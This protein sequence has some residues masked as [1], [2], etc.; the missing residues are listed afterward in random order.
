MTIRTRRIPMAALAV[1]GLFAVPAHAGT[2]VVGSKHDLRATGGVGSTPIGTNL[3]QVCVTCH[4]PHQAAGVGGAG[5]QD[6]LWNHTV[7]SQGL[8]GVYASTTAQAV[9]TDFGGGG[10]PGALNTSQLCMSC[11]DGTVGVLSMY[12]QPNQGGTPTVA[13][14]L[15]YTA[16]GL[17][18]AS[19]PGNV[20]T[21]LTDDHPVNFV[22]DAAL[23]AA[24]T[25]AAGTP[26][27]TL[28]PATLPLFA[29]MVQCSTCHDPHKNTNQPF[30]RVSNVA[31]A[32]CTTCHIK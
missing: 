7:S 29:T 1:V 20:G 26:G 19:N 21:S 8:Y 14:V 5:G 11:H 23:V 6:P 28:P 27:L 24:D 18:T 10:T 31:S 25:A 3:V 16:A 2:G 9:P 17:M 15:N 4:T 32:L 13:G 30:L 22:F 12:K